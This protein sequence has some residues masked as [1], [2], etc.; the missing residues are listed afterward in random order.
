[1]TGKKEIFVLILIRQ[2]N[3]NKIKKDTF[4]FLNQMFFIY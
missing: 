3:L 4:D 2:G 1:M